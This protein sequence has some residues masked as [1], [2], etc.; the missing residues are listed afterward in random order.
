VAGATLPELAGADSR[1]VVPGADLKYSNRTSDFAGRHPGRFF[2]LGI[3]E[4]NMTSVAA[5]IRAV[6]AA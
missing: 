3:A 2:N 1:I 6:T 4:Q 5:R